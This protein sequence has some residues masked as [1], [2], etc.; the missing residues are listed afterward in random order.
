MVSLEAEG[1][2]DL[3][4]KQGGTYFFREPEKVKFI[5]NCLSRNQLK[6]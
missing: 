4:K 3:R 6:K 2:R 5:L 1:R